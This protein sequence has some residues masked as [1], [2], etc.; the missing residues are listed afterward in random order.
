MR[1]FTPPA[2]RCRWP[3]SNRDWRTAREGAHGHHRQLP[4]QRLTGAKGLTAA[5]PFDVNVPLG[6]SNEGSI[7]M[8]A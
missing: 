8:T 7:W 5:E 2:A 6:L 3:T 4:G 1:R